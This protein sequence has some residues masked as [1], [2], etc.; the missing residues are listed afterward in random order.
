MK[1]V[2]LSGS[3]LNASAEFQ[4]ERYHKF[5]K[6]QEERDEFDVTIQESKSLMEGDLTVLGNS[7]RGGMGSKKE[8][9]PYVSV[10]TPN[11]TYQ[12]EKFNYIPQPPSHKKPQTA[13]SYAHSS[14]RKKQRTY[15]S[16][17]KSASANLQERIWDHGSISSMNFFNS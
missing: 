10:R 3:I 16:Q 11:K 14:G 9:S 12:S 4:R 15:S 13:S 6:I 8:M 7:Y 2:S 5:K 1:K 17:I